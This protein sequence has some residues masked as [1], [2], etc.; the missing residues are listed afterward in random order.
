M[1]IHGKIV[2][3]LDTASHGIVAIDLFERYLSEES[4][5]FMITFPL[6]FRMQGSRCCFQLIK[7]VPALVPDMPPLTIEYNA[8]NAK[9]NG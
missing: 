1:A 3:T 9:Q 8:K 5:I 4:T 7:P 2:Y 6:F